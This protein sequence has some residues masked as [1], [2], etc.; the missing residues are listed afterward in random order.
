MRRSSV[1]NR[2]HITIYHARRAMPGLADC[3]D[4]I[5]ITMPA[6]ETRFMVLAP[7]GE[8]PRPE[9]EPRNL[10]LELEMKVNESRAEIQAFRDRLLKYETREV[11]GIRRPSTSQANAFGPRN[12]QPHMSMILPW[13]RNRPRSEEG[14]SGLPCGNRC[15]EIRSFQ[16]RDRNS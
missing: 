11:L 6:A 8:N 10:S 2:L 16:H 12:F 15:P 14:W 9:L 7:G 5:S 3:S 4:A 1:M 13:K